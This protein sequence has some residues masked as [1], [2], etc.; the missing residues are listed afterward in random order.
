MPP[1]KS[2]SGARGKNPP[3]KRA[4]LWRNNFNWAAPLQRVADPC[5][6]PWPLT[7]LP[8]QAVLAAGCTQADEAAIRTSA[9][10]PP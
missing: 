7:A 10:G 4:G 9:G 6:H 3:S 1:G 2:W 8:I 5:T